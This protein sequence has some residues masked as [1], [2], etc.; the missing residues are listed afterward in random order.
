MLGVAVR[1][2]RV[3]FLALQLLVHRERHSSPVTRLNDGIRRIRK[4]VNIV[5][6]VIGFVE[7]VDKRNWRMLAS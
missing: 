3:N 7:A 2:K 1:T 6:Q 5:L 4:V